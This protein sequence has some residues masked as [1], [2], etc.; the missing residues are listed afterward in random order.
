M[1]ENRVTQKQIIDIRWRYDISKDR[2]H[3][4]LKLYDHDAKVEQVIDLKNYEFNWVLSN[5]RYCPGYSDNKGYHPC[6]TGQVLQHS[7]YDMCFECERKNGFK[8]AFFFGKEPNEFMKEYLSKKQFVYL[9][10]FS[11]DIIK[12]GTAAES[13]KYLRLI[14]QD[15][16]IYAFI[17]ESD[18][19]NIQRLEHSI[20]EKLGVTEFVRSSTKFRNMSLKPNVAAVVKL[21]NDT[22]K[23]VKDKFKDTEFESWLFKDIELQN[24]LHVD[25]IYFPSG[26]VYKVRKSEML[27]LSGKFKGIRGRYLILENDSDDFVIDER[28]LKG[29]FIDNYSENFIYSSNSKVPKDQLSMI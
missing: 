5:D 2:Y 25:N 23:K 27:N 16:L 1:K 7:N 22:Y 17:A 19:F 13:R 3:N 20:S 24:L 11:P 9:A 14:E 26:S 10:F 28:K 15:A 4:E 8:D 29:R 21:I 6:E 18:G 12:V